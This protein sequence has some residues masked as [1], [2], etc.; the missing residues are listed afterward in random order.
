[1]ETP[2]A[3]VEKPG[4]PNASGVMKAVREATNSEA[5]LI[6]LFGSK[7]AYQ[8]LMYLENYGQG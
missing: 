5:P 6:G 1:M 8:A 3:K 2:K 7:S 4:Q